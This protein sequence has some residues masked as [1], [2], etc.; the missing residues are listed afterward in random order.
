MTSAMLFAHLA[1]RVTATCDARAAVLALVDGH[2]DW[3][4]RNR[5]EARFM[6][7]A[8][9]LELG[10]D[11]RGTLAAAKAAQLAPVVAHLG[12]FIA[13]GALPPW[14]PL[15]FDLVLLGPS[16]EACRRYLAGGDVDPAWMRSALPEL[17][18][19][20]VAPVSTR[21]ASRAARAKRPAGR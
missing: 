15:V 20:C 19:R 9:A 8:M 2:L 10:G 16:H 5:R 12:R 18:W 1:A 21:S 13:A 14:S 4:V 11:R 3:V 7:Q 17:A 6:Y